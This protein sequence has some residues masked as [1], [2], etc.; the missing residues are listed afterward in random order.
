MSEG[1]KIIFAS[2]NSSRLAC[3]TRPPYLASSSDTGWGRSGLDFVVGSE[4]TIPRPSGGKHDQYGR[5]V[6]R[7]LRHPS[8][9]GRGPEGNR[10]ANLRTEDRDGR[11]HAGASRAVESLREKEQAEREKAGA[12]KP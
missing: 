11:G 7:Y 2:T 12:G 6:P 10:L 3:S 9:Q 5:K 1:Q 4:L 8:T